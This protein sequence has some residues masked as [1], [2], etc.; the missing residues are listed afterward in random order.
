MGLSRSDPQGDDGEGVQGGTGKAATLPGSPRQHQGQEEEDAGVGSTEDTQ[1]L[2]ALPGSPRQH[3][4]QEE[5]DAGVGSTEDTQGLGGITVAGEKAQ[6]EGQASGREE[7][8]G[9]F[10]DSDG[11][12]SEEGIPEEVSSGD[13]GISFEQ[14]SSDGA[15][16]DGGDDDYFS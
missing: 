7:S 10:G 13:D 4:G 11:E 9:Y 2:G 1:G 12:V 15:G 3:Q 6:G 8:G 14:D 5:E 16:A